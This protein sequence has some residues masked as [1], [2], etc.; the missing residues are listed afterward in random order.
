MQDTVRLPVT[1]ASQAGEARR[2]VAS[3]SARLGMDETERGRLA[4]I[5]TELAG[6]L[7]RHAKNGVL[8]LQS[9]QQGDSHGLELLALDQG[10]GMENAQ[11]CLVDGYSTGGT[12]GTGLGAVSRQADQFDIHSVP[13]VGTAI[14]A[15]VWRKA[16]KGVFPMPV[17]GAVNVPKP[18]EDVCGDDWCVRCDAERMTL[19][20]V[21]GLGHG[22]HACEAARGAV[23]AFEAVWKEGPVAVLEESHAALRSTRGAAMAVAEMRPDRGKV[24]FS[25]VGN[26]AA[27]IIAA[28]GRHGLISQNGTLGFE[29][30]RIQP[31][32]YDWSNGSL[33]VMHSD[34]LT[35]NWGLERYPGILG[36]DL[37]LIAGVLYRDFCRGRDDATVVVTRGEWPR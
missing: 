27:S 7:A 18:G 4:I 34:G 5:T 33:L 25:G 17:A 23:E 19:C 2:V 1:E 16:R 31:F 32:D 6:N 30:R 13:R 9:I 10:P 3:L 11:L 37:S 24:H 26:I 28:D 8:L 29:A 36:R 12:P 35:A 15:R 20:V 22:L 21:D 14:V